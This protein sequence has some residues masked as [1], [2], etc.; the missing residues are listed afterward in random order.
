MAIDKILIPPVTHYFGGMIGAA[1]A[2]HSEIITKDI[3]F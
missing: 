3:R 2:V 1:R